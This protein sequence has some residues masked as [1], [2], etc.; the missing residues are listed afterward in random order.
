MDHFSYRNG[1]LFAEDVSVREIAEKVGT[2]TYVYSKAT[3][4]DHLQKIREAYAGIDT[5][6]CYSV[7]A[8]GNINILRFLAEAGSGFD[9]VSGGELYRVL[10]AGGEPSGVV[11]AGVGKT[12]T[13]I[14]EAL[15]AGIAYFNVESGLQDSRLHNNGQE[16]NQ[17]RR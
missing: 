5:T 16:R 3:F 11:Y 1:S 9:V 10:Q 15:D 8:C 13:E 4:T 17:I 6:I 14:T 12:D 7:K 2:P